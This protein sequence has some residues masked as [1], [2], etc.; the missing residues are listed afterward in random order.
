MHAASVKGGKPPQSVLPAGLKP[1]YSV[2]GVGVP[3]LGERPSGAPASS[4]PSHRMR[5]TFK[6]VSER[7]EREQERDPRAQARRADETDGKAKRVLPLKD[8]ALRPKIKRAGQRLTVPNP[9]GY[10]E[11]FGNCMVFQLWAL[12]TLTSEGAVWP[13]GRSGW[14]AP[15]EW[16]LS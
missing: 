12:P 1:T 5:D 7:Q 16:G 15:G 11:V 3:G 6:R 8:R 13:G 14:A 4:S 9:V 2:K 10:P